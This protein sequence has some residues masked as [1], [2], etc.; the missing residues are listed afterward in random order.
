MFEYL[1]WAVTNIIGIIAMIV[2]LC[3]VGSYLD[4]AICYVWDKLEERRG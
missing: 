4:K 2:V 3:I 1:G